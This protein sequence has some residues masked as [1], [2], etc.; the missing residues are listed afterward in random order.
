[1]KVETLLNMNSRN[2]VILFMDIS[3][4]LCDITAYKWLLSIALKPQLHCHDFC[5]DGTTTHPDLS[6]RDASA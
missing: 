3:L 4:G 1:M 6:S 5:H 2:L